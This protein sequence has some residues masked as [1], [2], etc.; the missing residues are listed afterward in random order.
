MAISFIDTTKE[1]D[2]VSSARLVDLFKI[3]P[4]I[5]CQH[6]LQSMVESFPID[7][8]HI[9]GTMQF[10]I[11]GRSSDPFDIRSPSNKAAVSL[12]CLCAFL[13]SVIRN[14]LQHNNNVSV[15]P[16]Y[17]LIRQAI[18]PRPPRSQ[19]KGMRGSET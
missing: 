14:C 5:D 4:K 16:A 18:Q 17:S 10:N 8:N 9:K 15:L 1:F 6:K 11:A 13:C 2:L 12:R 7:M 3:L 19:D